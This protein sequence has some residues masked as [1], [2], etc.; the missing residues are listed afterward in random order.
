MLFSTI[1]K[2]S[3]LSLKMQQCPRILILG[4][5]LA[6]FSQSVCSIQEVISGMYCPLH[7]VS[8]SGFNCDEISRDD[9]FTKLSD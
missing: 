7:I 8:Y 9:I 1:I 3:L 5:L 2:M 6:H 4:D